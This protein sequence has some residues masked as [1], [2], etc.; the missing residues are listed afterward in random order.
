MTPLAIW[1]LNRSWHVFSPTW[2]DLNAIRQLWVLAK[3]F[4]PL[5]HHWAWLDK[6]VIIAAHRV[7][8]WVNLLINVSLL[9]ACI[10]I[11]NTMKTSPWGGGFQVSATLIYL[12][13]MC[14]MYD[15]PAIGSYP[16]VA[17]GTQTK[18]SIVYIIWGFLG[19]SW[20]NISR[21]YPVPGIGIFV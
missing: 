17:S 9:I 18:M 12:N 19:S 15:V 8:G 20:P 14:K 4:M 1:V 7:H 16:Q 10:A 5:L 6:L 2:W 11:P 21:K 13:L 3:I